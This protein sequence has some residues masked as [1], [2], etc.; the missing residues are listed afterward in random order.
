MTAIRDI[1]IGE[2]ISIDYG[3]NF[4]HPTGDRIESLEESYRFIC[5]CSMCLGPDVKRAFNCNNCFNGTVYPIGTCLNIESDNSFTQCQSCG[6]S[7]SL[8]Y[9]QIC[10][11]KEEQY[12]NEPLSTL[13]EIR[14]VCGVEKI[15]HESHHL[16]F[17]ASDDLAMLLAARARSNSGPT[18]TNSNSKVLKNSD[19]V[20]HSRQCYRD[21]LTAMGET[22]RL[23]EIMLPPVH[24]EKVMY[25]DRLGQL[26]VA[27]GELD[28]AGVN[29]MKAYQMSCL[30][31]GVLTPCTLQ[32][33]KLIIN[34]TKNLSEL[35]HHYQQTGGK[36]IM[37]T[38]DN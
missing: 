36:N 9:R 29:F 28:F 8:S 35:L 38:D 13:D 11:S 31:C 19:A 37:D 3:N 12:R 22:V 10:L 5:K 26:A 21:A 18:E 6:Q 32:I 24:H 30:A 4:Y 23:L 16:I 34:P 1:G 17:W 27:A 20:I 15:I 33:Q 2:R 14:H 7:P 25:Y